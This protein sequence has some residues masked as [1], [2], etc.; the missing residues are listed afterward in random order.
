MPRERERQN[1]HTADIDSHPSPLCL[2]IA[3]VG[4]YWILIGFRQIPSKIHFYTV[5]QPLP[6][7]HTCRHYFITVIF[8]LFLTRHFTIICVGSKCGDKL[9]LSPLAVGPVPWDTWY[10][11]TWNLIF[12]QFT[13][14]LLK[15]KKEK[16]NKDDFGNFGTHEKLIRHTLILL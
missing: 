4:R 15:K 5:G 13:M 7:E 8:L 2:N 10:F 1:Q 11:W 3:R 16:K 9:S 6:N 12:F 14:V